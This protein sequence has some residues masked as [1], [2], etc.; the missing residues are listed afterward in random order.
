MQQTPPAAEGRPPHRAGA[1]RADASQLHS[2]TH[3]NMRHCS[4]PTGLRRLAR[5]RPETRR[6]LRSTPPWRRPTGSCA[7]GAPDGGYSALVRS[8]VRA[9][10][11]VVCPS[12]TCCSLGAGV[13][14]LAVGVARHACTPSRPRQEHCEGGAH[15]RDGQQ[16]RARTEGKSATRRRSEQRKERGASTD[17]SKPPLITGRMQRCR[18]CLKTQILR[19]LSRGN[20]S[21]ISLD[22]YST[23]PCAIS[24]RP[25]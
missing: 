4:P 14:L 16:R 23:N 15:T 6:S 18:L 25:A 8:L 1:G 12:R 24:H 19:C 11:L 3:E 22:A 20:P 9:T 7:R 5:L 10:P 13:V 2:H 21:T 17:S